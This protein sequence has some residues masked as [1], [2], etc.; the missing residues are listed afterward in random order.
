MA[1]VQ[2]LFRAPKKHV[3]MEE[4]R[5]ARL[6]ADF[7][8]EG[9]AHA[10]AGVGRQV[11]LV[12]RE[13]LEAMEL[14]PGVLRENITTNGLNVNSLPIGQRLRIGDAHLEVTMVCTPCNQMERIRPGL[15]KELWGRRGMLCRVLEGGIIRPGDG[16]EKLT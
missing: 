4:L 14:I 16:V 12:D 7:G 6:V 11:L 8:F 1:T 5:E 9:C 2:N 15:R 10:K 3:P 13:T